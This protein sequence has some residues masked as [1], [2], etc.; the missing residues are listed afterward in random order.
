MSESRRV[1]FFRAGRMVAQLRH[2]ISALARW[3][4]LNVHAACESFVEVSI[5]CVCALIFGLTGLSLQLLKASTIR[6]R[7]LLAT[8]R[9]LLF[10]ISDRV[11]P[12]IRLLSLFIVEAS[13]QW[14]L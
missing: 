1:A 7:V 13:V 2:G 9:H 3:V 4:S 11:S 8:L 5:P 12:Q 6:S 14:Q 10:Y